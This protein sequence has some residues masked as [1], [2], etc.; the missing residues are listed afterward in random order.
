MLK[1]LRNIAIAL[2]MVVGLGLVNT[3]FSDQAEARFSKGHHSSRSFKHKRR[4]HHGKFKRHHRRG[5]RVNRG[6]HR[7]RR[8]VRRGH[9][10]RRG[11]NG[12]GGRRRHGRRF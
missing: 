6:H 11:H 3:G 7:G 8:I 1:K 10:R 2:T 5:R 9:G 12:R 4:G